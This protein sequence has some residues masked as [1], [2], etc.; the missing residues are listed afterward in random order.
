GRG[1]ACCDRRGA[2]VDRMHPVRLHVVREAGRAADAGDEDDL[3]AW[4]AE[5]RHEA[6]DGG[7]DGV[8]AAA[9]AP[10]HL[11]VGLEV[12]RRQRQPFAVAV[13]AVLAHNIVSI[14]SASSLGRKGTPRTRL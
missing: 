14:A 10:A 5:L 13:D 4:K 11:L 3:L 12:L 6:L 2:A 8:V 7:E 9:R 1:Q